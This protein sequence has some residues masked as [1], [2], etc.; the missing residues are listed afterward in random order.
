MHAGRLFVHR[1]DGE[2]AEL[3]PLSDSRFYIWVQPMEVEFRRDSSGKAVTATVVT[4]KGR[5]EGKRS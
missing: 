2:E 4:R 1:S 5:M 3:F